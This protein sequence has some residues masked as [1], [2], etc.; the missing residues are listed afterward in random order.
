MLSA[1]Y[2]QARYSPAHDRPCLSFG[3]GQSKNNIRVHKYCKTKASF[4]YENLMFQAQSAAPAAATQAEKRGEHSIAV[5]YLGD[6]FTP[7]HVKNS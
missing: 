7:S 4:T 1:G 3:D 6:K 2:S 5:K